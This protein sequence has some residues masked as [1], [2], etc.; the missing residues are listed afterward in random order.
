MRNVKN[1]VEI[2]EAISIYEEVDDCV[3]SVRV[4]TSSNSAVIIDYEKSIFLRVGDKL[5]VI[6]NSGAK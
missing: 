2:I 1:A 5:N 3:K 6:V 4:L